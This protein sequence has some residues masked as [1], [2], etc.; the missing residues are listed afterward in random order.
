MSLWSKSSKCFEV[1][2]PFATES[3]QQGDHTM[4]VL[5]ERDCL[6]IGTAVKTK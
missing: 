6:V 2:K 4:D 1:K 5:D 3:L